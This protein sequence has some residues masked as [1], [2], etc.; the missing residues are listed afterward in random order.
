MNTKNNQIDKSI[1][2]DLFNLNLNI[3]KTFEE[4]C[5]DIENRRNNDYCGAYELIKHDKLK[6]ECFQGKVP[7]AGAGLG[8]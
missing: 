8:K 5:N 6:N 2:K 7:E 4:V 1:V 3:T